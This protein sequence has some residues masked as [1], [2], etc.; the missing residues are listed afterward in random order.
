MV[1]VDLQTPTRGLGGPLN[2]SVHSEN[3]SKHFELVSSGSKTLHNVLKPSFTTF[4]SSV[5]GGLF[6]ALRGT[7]CLLRCFLQ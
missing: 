1:S 3:S 6:Q 2:K 4:F 7:S 5:L